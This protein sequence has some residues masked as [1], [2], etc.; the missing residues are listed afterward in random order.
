MSDSP[1]PSITVS[2]TMPDGAD[3]RTCTSIVHFPSGPASRTFH[4]REAYDMAYQWAAAL[5]DPD[6][7]FQERL[8]CVR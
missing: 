3:S 7:V 5:R 2:S 1:R 8:Y 6:D 4:G